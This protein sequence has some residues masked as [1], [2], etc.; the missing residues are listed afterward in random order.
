MVGITRTNAISSSTTKGAAVLG[1]LPAGTGTTATATATATAAPAPAP[2][3]APDT[4]AA[5]RTES[6]ALT[7]TAANLSK[8]L[9]K[10][11]DRSL[12]VATSTAVTTQTAKGLLNQP[13]PSRRLPP[14][15]VAMADDVGFPAISP[16]NLQVPPAILQALT[17]AKKI[18]VIGHVPPDGDCVGSALGLAR[19][20]G[21]IGKTAHACVD[22][23][24][25]GRLAGLNEAGDLKRAADVD[26]DY[27]LV[28]LVDVAQGARIGGAA[29]VLRKAPAV[30]VLD[31]HHADGT[32]VEAK[33]DDAAHFDT[34][35]RPDVASAGLLIAGIAEAFH[36]Q[37]AFSE[38]TWRVVAGPLAAGTL[39]DTDFFRLPG[40]SVETL[41]MF[42]HMVRRMDV[43]LADAE[44][45]VTY[46]FP[47][48]AKATLTPPKA[49]LGE[50]TT[51][52]SAGVGRAK[53][54]DA[55]LWSVPAHAVNDALKIA[56][57][58][59]PRTT[60][61]D[62]QGALL[63]HLDGDAAQLPLSIMVLDDGGQVRVSIRSQA[64]DEAVDLVNSL[65]PGQGGG[66]PHV[67]AARPQG[68]LN[69]VKQSLLKA[70][71][72]R[73]TEQMLSLR[74]GR[75]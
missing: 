54:G 52:S 46:A 66:K 13:L 34:W 53:F 67:A 75:N 12:I 3:P 71:K 8:A 68:S 21:A 10:S 37:D 2:A 56:T 51:T 43:S 16:A 74:V 40:A 23:P 64:A 31:H 30:M 41:G 47:D 48:D 58:T 60:A 18:L 62:V 65:F 9:G 22:A 61:A 28:I 11:R 17:S 42:K 4:F 72:I 15:A 19:L 32:A 45:P 57:Q 27:D 44:A 63:D 33:A 20:L 69:E 70:L 35:I 38:S 26:D 55:A 7:A 49:Q 1:A 29:D 5:S 6:P 73:Q 50:K 24:L 14:L 36:A 25:P 39:T 59:D